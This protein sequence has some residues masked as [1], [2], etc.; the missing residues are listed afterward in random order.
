MKTLFFLLSTLAMA[1]AGEVKVLA[2]WVF[3]VPPGAKD[4]A[5]FMVLENP[6]TKPVR[7]TG[8][9]SDQAARIAPMITTKEGG[10]MGMKDVPYLEVPAKGRA[11]LVPGGDHIMIYGLKAPVRVGEE[12]VFTLVLASGEKISISAPVRKNPPQ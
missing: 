10:R 5:A 4:T 7:V 6:G 8:G 2:P 1:A 12:F 9:H 3:A 11:V